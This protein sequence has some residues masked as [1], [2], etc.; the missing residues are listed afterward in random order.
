MIE[1]K[2][3]EKLGNLSRIALS[4][5]EK[6]VF[7][8]EIDAILGYVSRVKDAPS[9][10]GETKALVSDVFREDGAPHESGI[11]TEAILSSAPKREGDYIK[12]KKI[13]PS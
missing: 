1:R 12:V 5:E 6:D 3:V 4:E 10:G 2:D 7:V 9:G 11:F 13:L 8:S